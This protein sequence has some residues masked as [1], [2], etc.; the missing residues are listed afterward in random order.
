MV[1]L[2]YLGFLPPHC[3]MKQ[4]NG[5]S[6]DTTGTALVTQV[7]YHEAK[8]PAARNYEPAEVRNRTGVTVLCPISDPVDSQHQL[9]CMVM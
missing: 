2:S 4:N 8:K 5:S 6:I 9:E 1:F 3:K 7:Q